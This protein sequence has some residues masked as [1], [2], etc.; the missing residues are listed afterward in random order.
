MRPQFLQTTLLVEEEDE[1]EGKV[2]KMTLTFDLEI[3]IGLM[4]YGWM[5]GLGDEL[6]G[7]NC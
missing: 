3:G 7:L 4:E 2:G 6:Y 1:G 5:V